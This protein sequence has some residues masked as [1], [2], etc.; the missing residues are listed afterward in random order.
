MGVLL[1]SHLLQ[2]SSLFAYV[3]P[4][5]K[6]QAQNSITSAFQTSSDPP[7]YHLQAQTFFRKVN[8]PIKSEDRSLVPPLPYSP[9]CFYFQ[10]LDI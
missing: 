5:F 9:Y 1:F 8:P 4:F 6:R 3:R 7:S 10:S 2:V